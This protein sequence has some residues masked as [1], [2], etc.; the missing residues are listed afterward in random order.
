MNKKFAAIFLLVLPLLGCSRP[1]KPPVSIQSC[2]AVYS[3]VLD[4]AA[5][6]II[7]DDP[8]YEKYLI[9][10]NLGIIDKSVMDSAHKDMMTKVDEVYQRR[11]TTKE[12]YS[13]CTQHMT[14]PQVT[15]TLNAKSLDDINVCTGRAT[16]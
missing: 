10:M 8:D 9:L 14:D 15:C 4:I 3:H 6:N 5:W 16:R 7:K 11:G 2:D 13:F 12:F 1:A